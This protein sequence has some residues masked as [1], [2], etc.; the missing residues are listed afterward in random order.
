MSS[1]IAHIEERGRREAEKQ[2]LAEKKIREL[3]K[4]IWDL[5][6]KNLTQERDEMLFT[7][8]ILAQK[9]MIKLGCSAQNACAQLGY[10]DSI[11]QKVLPFLN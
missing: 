8:V 7:L 6:K 9:T 4:K 1:V 11:C 10:S 2:F 5:E 3:E